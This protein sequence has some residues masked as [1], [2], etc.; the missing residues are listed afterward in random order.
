MTAAAAAPWHERHKGKLIGWGLLVGLVGVLGVVFRADVWSHLVA[1]GQGG[2]SLLGATWRWPWASHGV[3]GWVLVLLVF[4]SLPACY[5]LLV[6]IFTGKPGTVGTPIPFARDLDGVR[7]VGIL[8]NGG[9]VVGSLVP[10][11]PHCECRIRPN[12]WH[13]YLD[14]WFTR[15]KCEDCGGI[16]VKVQGMPLDV[17][18]RTSRRIEAQ[19]RRGELPLA[20]VQ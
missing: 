16:N 20:G 5:W 3:P 15:F 13:D 18:D 6:L 1:A 11:C 9:V 14:G 4:A 17:V 19:W 7:W 12:Y 8:S 10:F 2:A